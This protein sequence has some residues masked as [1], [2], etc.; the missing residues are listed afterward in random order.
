[1]GKRIGL[2]RVYV[3]DETAKQCALIWLGIVRLLDALRMKPGPVPFELRLPSG[4]VSIVVANRME[5]LTWPIEG[6]SGTTVDVFLGNPPDPDHPFRFDAVR[7][8]FHAVRCVGDKGARYRFPPVADNYPWIDELTRA[9]P[10]KVTVRPT[11][12]PVQ[13]A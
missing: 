2:G 13:A 4:L 8:V 9:D 7:T 10:A 12:A 1:M 5:C 6:G 11:I 3:D